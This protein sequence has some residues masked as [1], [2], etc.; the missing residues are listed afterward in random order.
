MLAIRIL[1][2]PFDLYSTFVIEERFGFNKTTPRTYI[3]DKRRDGC[4]LPLSAEV[5]LALII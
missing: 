2:T 4:W 5:L 1:E 3:L